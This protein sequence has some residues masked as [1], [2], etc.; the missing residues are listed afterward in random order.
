MTRP[1]LP[2]RT[3]EFYIR[4]IPVTLKNYFK[5]YCA[6]RGIT[7]SSMIVKY[8]KEVVSNAQ[9]LDEEGE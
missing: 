8:M 4:G 7:M 3:T 6:K 9:K 2:V 5:A 1:K